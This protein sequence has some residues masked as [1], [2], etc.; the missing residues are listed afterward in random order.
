MVFIVFLDC[1]A[2]D[3]WLDFA[4]SDR[5]AALCVILK[6]GERH[7]QQVQSVGVSYSGNN[8][9]NGETQENALTSK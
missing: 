8:C 1:L 4:L 7:N 3:E 9:D 5:K 2:E 6:L